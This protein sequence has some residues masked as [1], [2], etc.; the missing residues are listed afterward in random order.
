VKLRDDVDPNDLHE[1]EHLQPDQL[2]D[3]LARA[4]FITMQGDVSELLSAGR[5]EFER[6]A[7]PVLIQH[8]LRQDSYF[9]IFDSLRELAD[10]RQG[11]QS[12]IF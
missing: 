8:G 10:K 5:G 1:L 12:V 11:G 3:L 7:H 9:R 4:I 6:V 2:E